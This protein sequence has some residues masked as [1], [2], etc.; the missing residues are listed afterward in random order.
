MH[1]QKVIK[2]AWLNR[3]NVVGALRAPLI[4]TI[5]ENLK[6]TV[7]ISC[8]FRCSH[9]FF[10]PAIGN[11]KDYRCQAIVQCAGGKEN[12]GSSLTSLTSAH[13]APSDVIHWNSN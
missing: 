8:L 7:A 2:A 10:K 6:I 13:H 4:Y 11:P 12:V 9:G 5:H 3:R 1:Y